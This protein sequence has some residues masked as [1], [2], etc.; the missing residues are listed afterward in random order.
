MGI[1]AWVL[2][3]IVLYL[4]MCLDTWIDGRRSVKYYSQTHDELIKE[5][6]DQFLTR[7]FACAELY[8]ESEQTLDKFCIRKEYHKSS[9]YEAYVIFQGI[10]KEHPCRQQFQQE[11]A[12]KGYKKRCKIGLPMLGLFLGHYKPFLIC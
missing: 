9:G 2:G 4:L 10:T 6:L 5:H 12:E 11:L 1:W 8:V 7:A 3:F